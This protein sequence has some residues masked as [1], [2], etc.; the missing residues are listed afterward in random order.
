MGEPVSKQLKPP[1]GAIFKGLMLG[2]P[3]TQYL[4]ATD[5]GYGFVAPLGELI[6]RNKSG[7][8]VLRVRDVGVLSPQLVHDYED[9]WLAAV[10]SAGRL[11]VFALADLPVMSKGKGVKIINVPTARYKSGEEKLVAVVVFREGDKLRLYSGKQHM[12]L[13]PADIDLYLGSRAQRGGNLPRGY[14]QPTAL[15]ID[16]GDL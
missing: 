16:R 14:R 3:E 9:D 11:L 13:K 12:K 4:L 5:A 2:S 8:A 6:S 7:K 15:E 10:T 1:Q